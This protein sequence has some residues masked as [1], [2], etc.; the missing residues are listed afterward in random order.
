MLPIQRE[1]F[2]MSI[3]AT[4]GATVTALAIGTI[5]ACILAASVAS[6]VAT[7]AYAILAVGLGAVSIAAI[8]AWI[9]KDSKDAETYFNKLGEHVA[10][11]VPA[12][13]QFFAQTLIM[14]VIQGI[15]EGISKA[16]TRKISGPDLT[17]RKERV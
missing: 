10:Y 2:I 1:G 9:D 4:A 6:T 11:A 17:I 5:G 12:F 15:S 8:T 14:S 13:F 16:I 7:I 3:N